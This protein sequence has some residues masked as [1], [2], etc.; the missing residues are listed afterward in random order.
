[1]PNKPRIDVSIDIL[2]DVVNDVSKFDIRCSSLVKR[3]NANFS[4][5][6]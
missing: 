1:M 6:Y 4:C 3:R 2:I 5:Q